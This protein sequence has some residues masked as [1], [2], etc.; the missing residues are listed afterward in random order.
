[1]E[2]SKLKSIVG[3]GKIASVTFI[4]RS[5]GAERKMLCRTGVKIGLTGKGAAYDADSKGLLTVYDMQKRAYRT[6]P[7]ENVIEVHARKI[8]H[9]FRP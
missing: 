7:A 2:L 1:M 6:I 8:Q 5:D 4:K 3:G 9:T